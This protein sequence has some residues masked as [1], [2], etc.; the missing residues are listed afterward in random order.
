MST[1]ADP[2]AAESNDNADPDWPPQPTGVPD[3]ESIASLDDEPIDVPAAHIATIGDGVPAPSTAAYAEWHYRR[4]AL[5]YLIVLGLMPVALAGAGFLGIGETPEWL[6]WVGFGWAAVH[7][8]LTF[9]MSMGRLKALVFAV[10]VSMVATAA[11]AS[12]AIVVAVTGE[13]WTVIGMLIIA[14]AGSLTGIVGILALYRRAMTAGL[15]R[16]IDEAG[17]IPDVEPAPTIVRPQS[18]VPFMGAETMIA[19]AGLTKFYGP[20]RALDHVSFTVT[21][22]EIVGFLGPNGAGKSTAMKCLSTYLEPT[23]GEA[24]IAGH[25]ILDEPLEVRRKV[26]YLPESTPLYREMK[27][28]DYLRFMAQAR[29][30]PRHRRARN[31][32]WVIE[33]CGLR[34]VLKMNI[35]ELSKGYRQRVGIAQAMV[36]EPPLLILDE[37]SSGLDPNQIIEIRRLIRELRERNTI[38]LSTHILQEV[39]AVCTRAIIIAR[40]EIVADGTVEALTEAVE[41]AGGACRVRVRGTVE[42][43]LPVLTATDGVAA[44]EAQPSAEDGYCEALVRG[45]GEGDFDALGARLAASC[46]TA[47]LALAEMRAE[48]LTLEQVFVRL[49]SGTRT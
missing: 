37:P 4:N 23:E 40:G 13:S 14:S 16:V 36:H 20:T 15:A 1:E 21:R 46:A 48:R 11:T 47:N 3:G 35:G 19:T 6:G 18:G 30:L 12:G 26:G 27:V 10:G 33:R 31:I 44:V 45:A 22:G 49:T 41:D 7:G 8:A 25:S 32:E 2:L 5:N 38:L 28:Q 43:V 24:W 17:G 42:Q 39:T 34:E 29:H 9:M